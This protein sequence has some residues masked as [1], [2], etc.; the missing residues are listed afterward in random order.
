MRRLY[1]DIMK[2]AFV[3]NPVRDAHGKLKPLLEGKYCYKLISFTLFFF[4]AKRQVNTRTTK[5]GR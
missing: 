5:C 2:R 3:A 4:V 1:F